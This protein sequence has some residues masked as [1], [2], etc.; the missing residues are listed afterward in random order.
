MQLEEKKQRKEKEQL[1]KKLENEAIRK[2][3]QEYERKKK[4][5]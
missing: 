5:I 4:A 2:E 1:E 3:Q